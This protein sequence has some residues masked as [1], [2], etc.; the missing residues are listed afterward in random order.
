MATL[1]SSIAY[2]LEL[3]EGQKSFLMLPWVSS[4][5]GLYPS[6][7]LRALTQ[8]WSGDRQ[9][10]GFASE[11]CLLINTLSGDSDLRVSSGGSKLKAKLVRDPQMVNGLALIVRR[12]YRARQGSVKR[13]TAAAESRLT[14]TR[15]KENREGRSILNQS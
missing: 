3:E 15:T 11:N 7:S 14:A 1:R 5:K 4:I 2:L 8:G 9:V 12:V 13:R 6:D 10:Q